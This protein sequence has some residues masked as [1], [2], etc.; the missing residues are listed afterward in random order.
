VSVALPDPTLFD[1]VRFPGQAP[2]EVWPP[3][4]FAFESPWLAREGIQFE[5]DA[6]GDICV[7]RRFEHLRMLVP[8]EAAHR[9]LEIQAGT[10]DFRLI[11]LVPA[12]LRFAETVG[13]GDSM[14]P[15]LRGEEMPPADEHHVYAA[16]EVLVEAIGERAG[17][18]GR[19]LCAAI[20]RVPPGRDMF[21][22]AVA[23]CVTD[24]GLEMA[25]IAPLARRLQRLAN[26]HARVLAAQA[27]Q[28]DYAAMERM[29]TATRQALARDR[30]WSSDLLT[31]ALSGL[32]PQVAKPRLAAAAI[33]EAARRSIRRLATTTDLS[34]LTAEQDA[35]RDRLID[36]ATFWQRL[37]AAWLAVDPDT[38]DRRDIE[39]L[40]RN[41]IRRVKLESL[42]RVDAA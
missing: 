15:V 25:A 28:P 14:P 36:I 22:R 30:R 29:I 24:S 11:R 39:A 7:V 20:R 6:S 3:D 4:S 33:A 17:E 13:P 8:I 19:A 2:D 34:K 26:A 5:R 27:Q 41:A 9:A 35:S 18:A 32:E 37:A 42:Y 21:E 16:T 12:A 1:P 38:T 23:A 10:R 40:T 31:Y